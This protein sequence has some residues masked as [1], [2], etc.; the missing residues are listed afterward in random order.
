MKITIFLPSESEC[1]LFYSVR[2]K[3]CK[4]NLQRMMIR[5]IKKIG[6]TQSNSQENM[7]KS[8]K[9]LPTLMPKIE[10]NCVTLFFKYIS[11][12]ITIMYIL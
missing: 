10:K 5:N 9:T 6:A 1:T 4:K 7:P 2:T 8:I 3:G 12:Q 11:H